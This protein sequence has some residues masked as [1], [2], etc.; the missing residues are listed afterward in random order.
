MKSTLVLLFAATAMVVSP[1]SG[2][3]GKAVPPGLSDGMITLY[4]D[5]PLAHTFSFEAGGYG[6]ILQ[7]CMVKNVGADL[8]AEGYYPGEFTVGI[9]GGSSGQ[10][11]DLGSVEGLRNHYGYD[12]TVG[13][14]QGFASIRVNGTHFDIL[15]NYAA[16]S[17]QTLM[18]TRVLSKQPNHVPIAD[19]HVYL[20]RLV[21]SARPP[22]ERFIKLLVVRYEPGEAVTIRWA[23]LN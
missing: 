19:D 6:G 12:E 13:G 20:V 21:D 8:D 7:D 22:N 17:T 3:A 23:E 4:V 10:I 14:G 11:L 1:G 15:R 9:E 18:Q 2:P 5:D 16:Q